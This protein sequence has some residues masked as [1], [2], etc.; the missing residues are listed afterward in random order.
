MRTSTARIG[1]TDARQPS[2]SLWIAASFAMWVLSGCNDSSI[3]PATAAPPGAD[4]LLA[5]AKA[6]PVPSPGGEYQWVKGQSAVA[7]GSATGRICFLTYVGG[8]FNGAQDWFGVSN[9]LGRWHLGGSSG[10]NVVSARARC[11][12][13]ASYSAEETVE[14]PTK[15]P[16]PYVGKDVEGTACGL[17]RVGGKFADAGDQVRVSRKG[18]STWT[19]F[20]NSANGYLTGGARCITSATTATPGATW[21]YPN[22][23]KPLATSATDFCFLTGVSG[24]LRGV[25]DWVWVNPGSSRWYLLGDKHQGVAGGAD[26]IQ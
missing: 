7:M 23:P 18:M 20:V 9:K 4:G 1:R 12:Q 8:R 2:V 22:P 14:A 6:V 26:C 24:P 13:V 16:V 19:L 5:D 10:I 11:R 15:E 21:Q 17:T 3:P 25:S